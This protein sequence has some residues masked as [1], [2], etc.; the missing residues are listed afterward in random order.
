MIPLQG[1]EYIGFLDADDFVETS[2]YQSLVQQAEESAADIA[3]SEV[4]KVDAYQKAMSLDD[5]SI[6]TASS[7][8]EASYQISRD[9]ALLNIFN[10]SSVYQYAVNKIY[11]AEILKSM[12]EAGEFAEGK[13]IGEDF[14]MV[15][16]TLC[17]AEKIVVSPND[18]YFYR[19][20]KDST[21]RQGFT[22][23][24][25][26]AFDKYQAFLGDFSE[27]P[28]QEAALKRYMM[29]EYMSFLLAMY[30]S[31][32]RDAAVESAI[33]DFIRTNRDDYIANTKDG[34][35]AKS[36]ARIINPSL[37]DFFFR[38]WPANI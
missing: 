5:D 21:T 3:C 23:E 9:E 11:K 12:A 27:T 16:K 25:R 34:L 18:I 19:V 17:R 35:K 24:R 22:P 36:F 26:L 10:R 15:Y 13:F 32:T 38:T 31:K 29:L 1:G 4:V 20:H 33:L 30:R 8:Q 28:E 14:D 37:S 7:P 6:K 2:F